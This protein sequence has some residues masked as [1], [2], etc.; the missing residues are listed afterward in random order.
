MRLI[1]WAPALLPICL[2]ARPDQVGAQGV[3]EPAARSKIVAAAPGRIEGSA[4]S[5]A[6]GAAIS[7]IVDKVTIRQ[8]DRVAAGQILVR[9][10]CREI[11]AQLSMR[12]AEHDAAAALYRRLVNGARPEEVDI[13]QADL[14][15]AE[16][17]NAEAQ[18]RLT[19][20][21]AL[22]EKSDVSR[23]THDAME[24]DA[25][26]A[27]AQLD[28]V[29]HRLRL[30][31]AGTREEEL[32]ESKARMIAAK[33]SIDATRLELSKCDV[34]SPVN[35]IVLRKH[36]SEGELVSLFFPAPLVTLAETQKYRVRA[37]V[38]EHDMPRIRKGQS[39][40][41]TI[42]AA[43][44]K[45]LRGRVAEIAPM[46][47]RRTIL[48]T[49]PADKSDRDILEVEIDLDEKSLDLPIGLRVSVV[50]LDE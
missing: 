50:F 2:L 37:E 11:E 23:A 46:M 22:V 12:V 16:A 27:S 3:P 25:R 5:V 33:H 26:M 39:V 10:A 42:N 40:E 13:V 7:G 18:S 20:S 44:R 43:D 19:R 14:R 17:R 32:A 34:K 8:G 45:R 49:D 9:I 30:L 4:Q 1:A 24:R 31:Q 36:V 6:V 15:L 21:H 28:A 35:G 48:T 41:I 47:G 38:D 29:R